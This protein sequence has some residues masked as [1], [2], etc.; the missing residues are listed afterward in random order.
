MLFP[1]YGR[2]SGVRL[3]LG[4]HPLEVTKMDLAREL[5]LFASYAS[6]TSYIGE[7][8][9]DFSANGRASRPA[10]TQAFEAIL[11]TP[12]VS[13][14]L[15]TLHSRGAARE[16]VANLTTARASR[17][18]LHWFSGALRD[19]DSALE[20]G[21]L[22]SI[23]P[24]MTRSARGQKIIARLPRERV[25]VETDGPYISVGGN[26]AEPRDVWNVIDYL[27]KHWQTNRR[28]TAA[29]LEENLARMLT[30]LA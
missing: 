1:L 10:Q 8:G 23:N 19:L 25:L 2:R 14:K 27:A 13:A 16:V 18:I 5:K 15:M 28:T 20:A 22:F 26:A 21:F 30:G 12:G 9:L 3:A 29:L 24:A 17:V 6:S 4:L 7:I 11:Q